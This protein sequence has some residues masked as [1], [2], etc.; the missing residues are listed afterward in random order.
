MRQLLFVA[1]G[2]AFGSSCRYLVGLFA[3]RCLPGTQV[4]VGTLIVN[5]VGAL[6]IGWLAGG[7]TLPAHWRHVLV[8]G[9][10]GGFTTFS[11]FSWDTTAMATGGHVRC[12]LLNVG[13]TVV[14]TLAAAWTGA[15]LRSLT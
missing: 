15:R 4:P 2:G 3:P 5:V 9:F 12:A 11:A 14:L 10:L 7:T 8:V 1:F 13:L 6:V